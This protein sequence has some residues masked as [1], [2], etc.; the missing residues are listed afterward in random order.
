MGVHPSRVDR[1]VHGV[2]LLELTTRVRRDAIDD[3][4]LPQ[5]AVLLAPRGLLV[6]GASGLLKHALAPSVGPPRAV[7]AEEGRP[8]SAIEN[9]LGMSLGIGDDLRKMRGIPWA[10]GTYCTGRVRA[11]DRKAHLAN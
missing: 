9:N 2:Y 11:L 6:L 5:S 10:S 8:F 4:L 3:N 7:E 1:G